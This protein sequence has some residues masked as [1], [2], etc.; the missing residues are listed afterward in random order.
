VLTASRYDGKHENVTY[1]FISETRAETVLYECF[2]RATIVERM[3]DTLSLCV[4]LADI[5]RWILMKLR[6]LGIRP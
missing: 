2:K 6:G 4:S 3:R 1:D 5:D